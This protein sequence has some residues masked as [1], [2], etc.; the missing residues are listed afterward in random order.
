MESNNISKVELVKKRGFWLSAFLILMF[1]A[2]PLTAFTYF[3]NPDM[4]IQAYPKMTAG[5]LYFMGAM[6]IVNVILAV[7]IWMWKKWGVFGFYGVVVIAFCINLYVGLG[8]A[9]SL[10]GLIGAVI[11]FFTTKNRWEH[12]V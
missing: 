9:G 4:I 11:I 12:F 6:S 3:S 7:G 5:I 8:I 1:I 2:N 10:V